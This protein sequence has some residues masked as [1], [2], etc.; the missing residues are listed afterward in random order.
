[1][2]GP[3][4]RKGKVPNSLRHFAG[5]RAHVHKKTVGGNNASARNDMAVRLAVQRRLVCAHAP[6]GRYSSH[7][8]ALQNVQKLHDAPCGCLPLV[9]YGN[10]VLSAESCDTSLLQ[11]PLSL[12][13]ISRG[14]AS[15]KSAM[16]PQAPSPTSRISNHAQRVSP[17]CHKPSGVLAAPVPSL[18]ASFPPTHPPPSHPSSARPFPPSFTPPPSLAH[19]WPNRH[20]LP[21]Q[22]LDQYH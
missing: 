21:E 8:W 17:I 3:C 13:L 4:R 19:T 7:M 11:W 9:R 22:Q 16:K 2:K 12:C 10:C 1:M 5:R 18:S 14:P 20:V 15:N 6:P